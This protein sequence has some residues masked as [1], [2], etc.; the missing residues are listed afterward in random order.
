[1]LWPEKKFYPGY[2]AVIHRLGGVDQFT[3]SNL[4]PASDGSS[5]EVRLFLPSRL[6]TPGLY[7]IILTGI[8]PN[9]T[10][11]KSEEYSFLLH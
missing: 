4:A 9:G 1:M 11:S 3:V 7:Q 8:E 2:R 10:T 5:P 6:L